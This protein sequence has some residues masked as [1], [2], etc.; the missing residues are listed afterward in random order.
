M[1]AGTL[2]YSCSVLWTR[3]QFC[4]TP[5]RQ[6]IS[7]SIKDIDGNTIEPTDGYGWAYNAWISA[8]YW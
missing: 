6:V 2:F 1:H 5:A 8:F 3:F 4:H 7:Q